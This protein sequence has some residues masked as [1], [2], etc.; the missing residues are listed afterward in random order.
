MLMILQERVAIPVP[1]EKVKPDYH[2]CDA[3]TTSAGYEDN[4]LS[5]ADYGLM[6]RG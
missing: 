3:I 5:A 6:G 2:R 1:A 4:R